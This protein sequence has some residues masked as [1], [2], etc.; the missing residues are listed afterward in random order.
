ME[1]ITNGLAGAEERISGI[2]D[3]VEKLLHSDRK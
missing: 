1:N 2:E 3:R